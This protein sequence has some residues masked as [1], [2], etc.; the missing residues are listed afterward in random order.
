MSWSGAVRFTPGRMLYHG[1]VGPVPRHS[2]VAA[3][4][5]LVVS[6]EVRL[7]DGVGGTGTPRAAVLPPG[8]P[9][10][11]EPVGDAGNEVVLVMLEPTGPAGR[12]VTASLGDRERLASWVAAAAPAVPL[13]RRPGPDD[14]AGSAV[15][16]DA[17]RVLTAT[18]PPVPPSHPALRRALAAIPDR[19][20]RGVR[21]R[22]LAADAGIS[23]GRLG[24]LF[25]AE[26]GLPFGAYLR[27]ARLQKVVAELSAG[28]S[29]T[30]AAHA[31]GFTDGAHMTRT[32]RQVFGIPPSEFVRNLTWVV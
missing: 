19:L 18:A 5:V 1:Q 17:L 13:I 30:D 21:L 22:D 6:G 10:A 7:S 16:D 11:L 4:L 23:A 25:T 28:A 9:Y 14:P 32:G 12:A 8:V 3:G 29:L 26:L 31:A 20:S 2:S 27:W 15:I 24:H